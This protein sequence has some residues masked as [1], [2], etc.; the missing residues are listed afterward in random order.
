MLLRKQFVLDPS[1]ERLLRKLAGKVPGNRSAVV[2]SAINY[3]ADVEKEL[4]GIDKDPGFIAMMEDSERAYR[5]GRY[6]TLQEVR[7][8]ARSSRAKSRK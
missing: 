3:Y 5:E 7:R 8:Q 1:T 2:R 6:S 4:E